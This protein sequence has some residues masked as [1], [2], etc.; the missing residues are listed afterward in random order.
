MGRI[1]AVVRRLDARVEL[2]VS[3]AK[4]MGRDN[5]KVCGFMRIGERV[6]HAATLLHLRTFVNMFFETF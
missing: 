6:H 5:P 4:T 1:H 3:E 2:F